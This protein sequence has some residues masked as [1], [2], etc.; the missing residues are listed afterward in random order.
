M[1][2]YH[3]GNNNDLINAWSHQKVMKFSCNCTPKFKV[4]LAQLYA[5]GIKNLLGNYSKYNNVF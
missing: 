1:H 5:V 2:Y 4:N 3:I